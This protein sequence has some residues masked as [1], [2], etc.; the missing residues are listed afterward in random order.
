MIELSTDLQKKVQAAVAAG[1]PAEEAM[2]RAVAIQQKSSK[3]NNSVMGN[4]GLGGFLGTMARPFERAAK[5]TGGAAF[6][7]LRPL[8]YGGDKNNQYYD[9]ENKRIRANP[10]LS[11]SDLGTLSTGGGAAKEGARITSGLASYAVPFGKGASTATRAVLPGLASGALFEGS[12]PEATTESVMTSA[13]TSAAT[14]GVLDKLLSNIKPGK[15]KE[16]AISGREKIVSPK[17]NQS[18]PLAY[19][20][21]RDIAENTL[22]AGLVGSAKNQSKQIGEIFTGLNQAADD[23]ARGSG[24]TYNASDIL[25]KVNA[26]LRGKMVM[27]AGKVPDELTLLMQNLSDKT[28]IDDL[29]LREIQKDSNDVLG[30]IYGSKGKV[31]MDKAMTQ[32]ETVH[33]AIRDTISDITKETNKPLNDVLSQLA[34]IYEEAPGINKMAQATTRPFS[35]VP[36]LSSMKTSA[37]PLQAIQDKI[38]TTKF[39]LA[40]K[41]PA[42]GLA[43]AVAPVTRLTQGL[44]GAQP[45]VANMPTSTTP[46]TT[47]MATEEPQASAISKLLTPEFMQYAAMN[48]P[49]KDY[50]RLEKAYALSAEKEPTTEAGVARKQMADLSNS[51]LDDFNANPNIKTGMIT[52]P[53]E[54]FKSIFNKADQPTLNFQTKLMALK[55]AIVKARAGT[56]FSK[57]EKEILEAYTPG[58]NDSMQQIKTKLEVLST[59][60]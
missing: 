19:Q 52:G 21:S 56:N 27:K 47:P 39:N 28:T 37:A 18:S 42:E 5:V 15:L 11:E 10:F 31:A 34:K 58:I 9:V 54:N 25:S 43:G 57:N 44:S 29:A 33:K 50:A 14:A 38:A 16:S 51:L 46:T 35:G 41:L 26:K 12:N 22:S 48:L 45:Q 59:I 2:A 36:I 53:A 32:S 55:G 60:F 7:L 17:V 4:K 23:L 49:E 1:A 20:Q 8:L 40:N 3:L 30:T 13:I 24:N 6:E